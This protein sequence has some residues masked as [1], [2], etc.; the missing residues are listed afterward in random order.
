[1]LRH[2]SAAPRQCLLEVGDETVNDS[3]VRG[4]AWLCSEL[5]YLAG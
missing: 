3:A 1:M 2:D 5:Q 4:W